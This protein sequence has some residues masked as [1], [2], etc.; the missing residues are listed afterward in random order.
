V[1]TLQVKDA[2]TLTKYLATLGAGTLLDPFLPLHSDF[3]LEVAK[4]NVVGHSFNTK[5]GRNP[6]IDVGPEDI[7]NSGGTYTGQPL[8]SASAETVE[9]FS[10]D[11][12]D[13]SVG[14]GAR[15]V[16]ITGLDSNWDEISETITLN[17]V[18]G[19]TSANSY[20]RLYRIKVLTAGSGAGNAG[21]L[22]CRHTT[23]TANIFAVLPVGQNQTTIAAFT[24]PAGYTAIILRIKNQIGRTNGSA[25]SADYSLRIREEDGV[26]GAVRY[27]T[28]T[29][30]FPDSYDLR[31]GIVLPAKTDVKVRC[32]SV[33]DTNTAFSS[34]I[35]YILIA[36]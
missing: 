22:T 34:A 10:S 19:V 12:A 16:L 1:S 30:N 24:V 15:T 25:G 9:V 6:D 2:N 27:E 32:E 17:G 28:I 13:T 26:Y 29:T 14:T 5:F 4:G 11:A 33:S 3:F 20:H 8:H 35:E 21:T 18:T 31:G 36:D 7:W 23:T